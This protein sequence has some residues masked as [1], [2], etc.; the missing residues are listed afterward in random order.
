MDNHNQITGC[1]GSAVKL[2]HCP[3]TVK[4]EIPTVEN[5]CAQREGDSRVL[6]QE[7]GPVRNYEHFRGGVY[8]TDYSY[9]CSSAGDFG[10]RPGRLS[11]PST[12]TVTDSLGAVI[13]GATV[14]LVQSGKDI[15]TTTSD[16]AGKFQF[17]IDHAG[18]YSVRAEAKTFAA[19]TSEEVFAEPGH[20]VDV[21]L[22]LS[23]SVVAQNIVVTATGIGNP[24]SADGH[25][26]QRD[27]QHRPETTHRFAA[28]AAR[29]GRAARWCRPGRWAA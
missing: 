26:D 23:P 10:R 28:G 8:A 9:C 4:D 7:T 14:V 21:S 12:G 13:S 11:R 17:K 1:T 27:R 20:S 2:R 16:A 15:S 6:S 18:R 29:S 24:G 25:L 5:H 22:T 19:S 3:A